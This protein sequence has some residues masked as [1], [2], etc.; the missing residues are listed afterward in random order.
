MRHSSWRAKYRNK[1]TIFLMSMLYSYAHRNCTNPPRKPSSL[2]R[3]QGVDSS[4]DQY[5]YIYIHLP[6][7]FFSTH[8]LSD[9][10]QVTCWCDY[11][12]AAAHPYGVQP[13]R[14][15]FSACIDWGVA[16]LCTFCL[17]EFHR[18]CFF[19]SIFFF[20]RSSY[21]RVLHV[22]LM[23]PP[24]FSSLNAPSLLD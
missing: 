8:L 13:T 14:Q 17:A 16:S 1:G 3:I 4:P 12:G 9:L 6:V 11:R 19:P 20:F 24:S 2:A 15:T 22:A 7:L 5:I 23:C 18:V 10:P 21:D